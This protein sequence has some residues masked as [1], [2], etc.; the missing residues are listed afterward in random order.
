MICSGLL[1][2]DHKIYVSLPEFLIAGHSFYGVAL[3]FYI[4]TTRFLRF[5]LDF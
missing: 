3:D 5:A 2:I 1:R 4:I